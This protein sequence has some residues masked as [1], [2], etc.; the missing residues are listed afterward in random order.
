MLSGGLAAAQESGPN[1]RGSHS[2][3]KEDSMTDS[4]HEEG[5]LAAILD[6]FER[7]RLPRALE[8]KAKVDRGERLDRTDVDHLKNVFADA[9]AI[10]RFVD[11]RPDL[12]PL[13]TRALNLYH[14]ITAKALENEE[15]RPS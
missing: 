11:K 7:F 8:I 3:T 15:S 10:K 9:E 5:V 14:A 2:P 12:Q 13:Y 4:S 1:T 6:R